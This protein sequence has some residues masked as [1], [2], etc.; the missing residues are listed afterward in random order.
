MQ[1]SV[2]KFILYIEKNRNYNYSD[3]RPTFLFWA[4]GRPIALMRGAN[5]PLLT[6][7]IHQEVDM[8]IR[9]EPRVNNFEVD[10][11]SDRVIQVHN[12]K[13]WYFN[14]FYV[15]IIYKQLKKNPDRV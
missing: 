1:Y 14:V 10:F 8:E 15:I 12:F 3:I 13:Q 2:K 5:R 11:Y 6:K 9:Q 4:R 7:L